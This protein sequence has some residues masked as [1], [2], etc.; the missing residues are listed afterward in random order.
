M[1]TVHGFCDA[2]FDAVKAAFERNFADNDEIGTSVAIAHESKF[3]V[4]L[5]A[6]HLSQDKEAEWSEDTIINVWSS[7]KTM[8][9]M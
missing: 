7:T 1:P 5:W 8:T 2:R 6:R 9:A 4:D 3:V